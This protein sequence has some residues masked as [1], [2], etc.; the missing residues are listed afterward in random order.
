VLTI[1]LH[2][3][4]SVAGDAYVENASIRFKI[5]AAHSMIIA[6]PILTQMQPVAAALIGV[7]LQC[8]PV[9]AQMTTT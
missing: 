4:C 1:V 6:D 8:L 2:F 3:A 5:K 7:A 9:A